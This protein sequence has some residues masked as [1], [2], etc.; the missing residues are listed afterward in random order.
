MENNKF[1]KLIKLLFPPLWLT[2]LL[3]IF[4][5]IAL[6]IVFVKK[7]QYSFFAYVI[8][9]VSFYTLVVAC[10]ACYYDLPKIIKTIKVKINNNKFGKRYFSDPAFQTRINLYRSLSINLLYVCFNLFLGIFYKTAWFI[11]FAI[12]YLSFIIVY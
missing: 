3:V 6:T 2:I 11:I 9:A 12:Y 7:M 4:S 1:K 5:A 8:Y 10:L